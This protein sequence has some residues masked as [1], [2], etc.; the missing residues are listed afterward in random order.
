M[1][2]NRTATEFERRLVFTNPQI[3]IAAKNIANA[4]TPNGVDI[5]NTITPPT[6]SAYKTVPMSIAIIVAERPTDT[7]TLHA[8]YFEII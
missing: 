7:P 6:P 2:N 1:T 5:T 4:P 3:I 8:L